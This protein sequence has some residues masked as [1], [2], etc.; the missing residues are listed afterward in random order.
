MNYSD[1]IVNWKICQHKRLNAIIKIIWKYYF[2]NDTLITS[3]KF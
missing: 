1:L 3:Y 2:D